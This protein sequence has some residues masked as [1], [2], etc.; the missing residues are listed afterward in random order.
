MDKTSETLLKKWNGILAKAGLSVWNGDNHHAYV[1]GTPALENL[2]IAARPARRTGILDENSRGRNLSFLK[3]GGA[4]ESDT[5]LYLT[6]ALQV[7]SEKEQELLRHYE[8]MKVSE[9]AALYGRSENAISS[10]VKRIRKKL[11]EISAFLMNR[12]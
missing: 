12:N 9:V 6:A 8:S 2:A 5:V 1:G 7:L 11:A 4:G 10:R 3:I